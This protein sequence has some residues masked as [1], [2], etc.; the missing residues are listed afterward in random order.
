VTSWTRAFAV[1]AAVLALVAS[2]PAQAAP[3]HPV[4]TWGASA[5]EVGGATGAAGLVDR[6][7]RNLVHTS[8]G[9]SGVRITLSNVFGDRPVTFAS[10]H[11]GLAG[12]GGAV[13]GGPN[14]TGAVARGARGT[15][16]PGPAVGSAPV[17][18]APVVD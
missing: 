8:L 3:V 7:V 11:V 4:G 14:S 13:L 5:D 1:L 2:V 12:D 15:R 16:P 18:P 17:G 6:S 9:G 10:V